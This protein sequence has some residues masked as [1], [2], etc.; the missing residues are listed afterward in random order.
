MPD[1]EQHLTGFCKYAATDLRQHASDANT[2]QRFGGFQKW[3]L[4]T[5]AVQGVANTL[6][7]IGSCWPVCY[8]G[9]EQ[10]NAA[11]HAINTGADA[12]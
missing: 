6:R 11:G 3:R 8:T 5:A 10:V 2:V 12:S 4:G 1:V 9:N 7:F